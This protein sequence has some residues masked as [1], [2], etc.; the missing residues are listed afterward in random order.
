MINTQKC[1]PNG[2]SRGNKINQL[3][4]L[5][6]IIIEFT[7][8][9]PENKLLLISINFTLKTSHSCLKNGTLGF[10]G[11]DISRTSRPTVDGSEILHHLGCI[12]P[13]NTGISTT[14]TH[15]EF[16]PSIVTLIDHQS[17]TIH[18]NYREIPEKI[19]IHLYICKFDDLISSPIPNP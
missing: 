12:K 1:W 14:S 2:S 7:N 13:M 4:F 9:V 18:Y 19:T 16:L 5:S 17:Q 6:Q 3:T 8:I 10:A 11:R 15:A